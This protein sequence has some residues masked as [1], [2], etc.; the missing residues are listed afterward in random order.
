MVGSA[1]PFALKSCDSCRSS[2]SEFHPKMSINIGYEVFVFSFSFFCDNV[3][4]NRF[5]TPADKTVADCHS[6]FQAI[7]REKCHCLFFSLL[8]VSLKLPINIF[9]FASNS[10]HLR[11]RLT[12]R[13][14]VSSCSDFNEIRHSFLAPLWCLDASILLSFLRSK[15]M[16]NIFQL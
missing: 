8:L 12:T 7:K 11:T 15:R 4:K 14:H 9:F 16:K 10:I 13:T 2:F 1:S 6:R 3:L 5:K